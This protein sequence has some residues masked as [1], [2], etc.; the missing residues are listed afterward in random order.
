[1]LDVRN[2]RGADANSDHYLVVANIRLRIM[3]T[4]KASTKTSRRYNIAKL[5]NPAYKSDFTIELRNKYSSLA[6]DVEETDINTHWVLPGQKHLPD[7]L[8]A[9]HWLH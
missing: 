6:L 9:I 7:S 4:K 1:M 8:R 3:A 5:V 2:K